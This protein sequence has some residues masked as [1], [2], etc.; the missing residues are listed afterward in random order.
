MRIAVFTAQSVGVG[1]AAGVLVA[2]WDGWHHGAAV[3][4]AVLNGLAGGTLA[5]AVFTCLSDGRFAFSARRRLDVK[6]LAAAVIVVPMLFVDNLI[7]NELSWANRASLSLLFALTG[8]AAY[9]LGGI[10]ATLNHLDPEDHAADPRL[11]RLT[12]PSE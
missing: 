12:P 4:L 6:M 1:V 5:L 2:V 7:G 9:A 3:G 8:F 11:H 10:M